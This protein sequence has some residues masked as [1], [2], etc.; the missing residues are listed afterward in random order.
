M[1]RVLRNC[2]YRSNPEFYKKRAKW[3]SLRKSSSK[4][5]HLRKTFGIIK[6]LASKRTF[7]KVTKCGQPFSNSF[8][9]ANK[10]LLNNNFRNE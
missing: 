6:N 10:S 5:R 4:L 8:S 1:T 2:K 7:M 9:R 3:R